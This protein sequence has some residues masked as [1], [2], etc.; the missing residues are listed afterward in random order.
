MLHSF[1]THEIVKNFISN[2]FKEKQA[3]VI[4]K[5]IA[6]SRDN[7]FRHL[8][9]KANIAKLKLEVMGIRSEMLKIRSEL[10]IKIESV[11]S[12]LNSRIDGVES[13]IDAVESKLVAKID[14]V[15][16]KLV[17]KIAAV[18]NKLIAK[19]D[20]LD[21]RLSL[22]IAAVRTEIEKCKNEMLRWFI[23]ISTTLGIAFI[24]TM[25]TCF[26]VYLS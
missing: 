19:I 17:A 22:E 16:N 20:N 21:H 10:I 9:T 2:G 6:E 18:E 14:A 24:T 13:K 5:A 15:E 3:E 26:K 4:V 8:A 23:G 25:I 12:Q 7:D 11:E 1:D